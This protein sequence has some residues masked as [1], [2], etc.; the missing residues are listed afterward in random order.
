MSK[1]NKE[2]S[3]IIPIVLAIVSLVWAPAALAHDDDDSNMVDSKL[4]QTV[5]DD[6]PIDLKT[7]VA[8]NHGHVDIGPRILDGKWQLIARDDSVNPSTWRSLD[9]MVFQMGDKSIQKLPEGE[10]YSFTGAKAGENVWVIP[11]VEK[12]GVPWLGWSTQSPKVVEKVNG[13]V[14]ITFE[15]HQ[16]PGILTVFTQDGNFSA[17]RLLWDSQ[18]KTAQ[19]INVDTNTH[20]HVNWVFT[21]PGTHLVRISMS[22]TLKDGKEVSD[23]RIL[24]FAIGAKVNPQTALETLWKGHT[25]DSKVVD[26]APSKFSTDSSNIVLYIAGAV[27]IFA[28]LIVIVAVISIVRNRKE[29]SRA[30]EERLQG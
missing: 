23:S 25:P 3:V 29:K 1:P 17:P 22:A 6:E 8:L 9:K 11:Q 28:L 30:V 26:Q 21:K 24:R 4:V 18:K 5:K 15:G 2:L 13:Q 27:L 7:A 14:K 19:A 20:T 10:Q 12:E 16:G